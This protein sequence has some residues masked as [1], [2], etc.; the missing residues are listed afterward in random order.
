MSLVIISYHDSSS[1]IIV[2]HLVS[3][4]EIFY[5]VRRW[6]LAHVFCVFSFLGRWVSSST[7]I[8]VTTCW[9]NHT[10]GNR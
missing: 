4:S 10:D 8:F 1:W 5:C 6:S 9:M 7:E 3:L 2:D